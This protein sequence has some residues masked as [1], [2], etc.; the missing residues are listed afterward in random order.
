MP[1]MSEKEW[2][3]FAASKD[4][5]PETGKKIEDSEPEYVPMSKWDLDEWM[6]KH[7]R[8]PEPQKTWTDYVSPEAVL[9]PTG[10]LYA[11]ILLNAAF[12]IGRLFGGW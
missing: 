8:P 10:L 1:H 3:V 11:F 4:L 12:W 5:D 6:G 2:R 9:L 7:K